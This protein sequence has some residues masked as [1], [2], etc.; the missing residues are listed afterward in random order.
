MEFL[1]GLCV[2]F[3]TFK[4]KHSY[5]VSKILK[6]QSLKIWEAMITKNTSLF[7][8]LIYLYPQA[9]NHRLNNSTCLMKAI[10]NNDKE[11][12]DILLDHPYI[13]LKIEDKNGRDAIYYVNEFCKNE[14]LKNHI[15]NVYFRK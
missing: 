2:G 4:I 5:Q 1:L 8:H 3:A 10:V 7:K 11:F 6:A 15:I 13:N 9:I 14:A 12:V